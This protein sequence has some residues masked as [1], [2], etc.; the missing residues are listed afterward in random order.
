MRGRESRYTFVLEFL[1]GT[2][3]RQATGESPDVALC[4]WLR[5]AS[6]EVFEWASH[7]AELL[8][9]VRDEVPVPIEGCQNVWCVSGLAG[10]QS[11]HSHYRYGERPHSGN[12]RGR[13]AA[14]ATWRRRQALGLEKSPLT[15]FQRP[16][17]RAAQ[18][19]RR[20]H[21]PAAAFWF[22]LWVASYAAPWVTQSCLQRR[23]RRAAP[24]RSW[25]RLVAR[26]YRR[27]DWQP[28]QPSQP[29]E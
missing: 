8:R 14:G 19:Q 25:P 13:G 28:L 9:A 5:L 17:T 3:V 26:P 6:E 7:R 20:R 24:R 12:Q 29:G 18:S 10:D 23:H 22:A 1:G 2:Y 16:S 4:V 11:S 21:C 27:R 15:R